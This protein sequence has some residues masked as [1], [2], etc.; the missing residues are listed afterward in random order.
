[1]KINYLILLF[2]FTLLACD[3]VKISKSKKDPNIIFIIS[4]DQ[5][6]G[7][8]SFMGHPHLQTPNIDQLARESVTYSKGYVTSPLCGPSLASIITGKYAFEHQQTGND[9]GDSDRDASLWIKNGYKLAKKKKNNNYLFSKER[10]EKF[11]V[12]KNEFYK[13]KLLTDYLNIKGYKS[14]Q[15]G[16]WWLGSWE[17][18][19]FDGGMTHGDYTRQGR[20]GD[21]GL[22]IGREGLN[23]IFDFIDHTQEDGDPFFVWYAPFLPHT[24][25]DPPQELLDKYIKLAPSEAV[26]KYWA[27]C[28]WFDK[29]VGDLMNYLKEKS[30][31]ENTLIVYTS[32]NGWIQSNKRNRYAPRSKR[33]PHEGGI[34]TPIMFKLPQVI[35]PEMNTSTL[36]SNIDLVP[37]VLDFLEITGEE[38]SGI[39]VME[40]EKLNTRETLFIECYHHD[41]L[42]VERPTETVLYK[43]ALNK[44]WKLMLPNTKMI[45][46]EFTQPEEQYYGYYSN[47]PQLYDLQNDPEEKV[48]LAKQHP[49]IVTMLSNQINNWWQPIKHM[50]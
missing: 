16:K 39:S 15:S 33:A 48:N 27:M 29:T 13:N 10:N 18:G 8:Y 47:Q 1:M 35:E 43:V 36:V 4:D 19:K 11:D 14:F 21:E 26:A 42:N 46:R 7:D 25:H 38:L 22:K 5:S 32:D 45:V 40:K 28:E 6:W 49:D 41:I 30:L 3:D 24:P 34:R 44:K 31:D 20:H 2:I 37:T 12:I 17:E 9:A 50:N 23:P